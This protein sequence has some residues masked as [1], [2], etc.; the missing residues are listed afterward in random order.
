MKQS[1]H[2]TIYGPGMRG[3]LKS[4]SLTPTHLPDKYINNRYDDNT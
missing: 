2:N 3:G 4:A 1:Q